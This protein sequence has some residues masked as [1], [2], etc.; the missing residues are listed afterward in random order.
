MAG[1]GTGVYC[2]RYRYLDIDIYIDTDI[3]YRY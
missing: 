1:Q 3:D 2:S